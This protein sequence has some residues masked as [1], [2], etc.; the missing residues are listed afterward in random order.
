MGGYGSGRNGGRPAILTKEEELRQRLT[1]S[2]SEAHSMVRQ[3]LAQ[4]IRIVQQGQD[5]QDGLEA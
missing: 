3:Y 2:N 4:D 5:K 1:G